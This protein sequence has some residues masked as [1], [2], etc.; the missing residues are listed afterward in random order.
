M[1]T[2]LFEHC[3]WKEILSQQKTDAKILS[4]YVFR[5]RSRHHQLYSI[6]WMFSYSS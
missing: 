2:L 4:E 3:L 1:I 5:Q 6:I